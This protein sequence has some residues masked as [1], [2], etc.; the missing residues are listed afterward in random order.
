M[1]QVKAN[2]VGA[3]GAGQGSDKRVAGESFD[4]FK[5]RDGGPGIGI[6]AAD[7]FLLAVGGVIADGFIDHVAIAVG[8][9]DDEG[10]ILLLNFARFELGC[11][12]IVR[13]VVFGDDDDAAC[14]AVE[15][16]DDSG[17]GGAAAGAELAEVVG[18]GAGESA[19]PMPLGGMHDHAGSFVDDDDRIVFIKDVKRNVL[20]LGALAWRGNLVD[21]DHIAR[22]ESERCFARG[23]VDTHVAGVDRAAQRGAAERGKLLGEKYVQPA[24]GLIGSDRETLRPGWEIIAHGTARREPR[25]P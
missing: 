24:A 7:R 14:F 17:A 23:V 10:E 19:F 1:G 13:L 21:D 8:D 4:R 20:R 16:V 18:E 9:A 11:E 3:A 2:L 25:P 5:Y 12:G 15:P 6:F 22:L